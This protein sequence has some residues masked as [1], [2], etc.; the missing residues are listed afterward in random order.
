VAETVPS[1][2]QRLSELLELSALEPGAVARLKQAEEEA[3][4]APGD[5]LTGWDEQSLAADAAAAGLVVTG[6]DLVSANGPRFV[7][8]EDVERWFS[9]AWGSALAR[10]LSAA[11]MDE[12]RRT[13]RAQLAGR[14]VS[15]RTA[16]L[17]LAAEKTGG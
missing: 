11:E 17:F 14:E 1:R 16:T 13:C 6:T 9:G 5:L 4:S 15:W 10:S 3:Y 2:G 7:R 12:V 8:D